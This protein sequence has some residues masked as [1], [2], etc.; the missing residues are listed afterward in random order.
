MRGIKI[1]CHPVR[2]EYNCPSFSFIA[3]CFCPYFAEYL[4]P[5]LNFL[6]SFVFII[7]RMF[8]AAWD[9][10]GPIWLIIVSFHLYISFLSNETFFCF[11]WKNSEDFKR[12]YIHLDSLN[13]CNL[14][15]TFA[16]WWLYTCS[17]THSYDF[18]TE[19]SY[20]LPARFAWP[21]G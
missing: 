12:K 21:K 8:S 3:L 20:Y 16:G 9:M 4:S 11:L 7:S 1:S 19:L 10:T 18:P 6:I 5:I 2:L 15:S 14:T 13:I 17:M